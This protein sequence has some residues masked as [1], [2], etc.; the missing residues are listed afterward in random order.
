[1]STRYTLRRD[2]VKID[3]FYCDP[4][5]SLVRRPRSAASAAST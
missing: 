1:M 4:T 3:D 2:N 5:N